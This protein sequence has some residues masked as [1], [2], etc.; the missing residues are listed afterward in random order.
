MMD[1]VHHGP[2]LRS[3]DCELG[4]TV[5]RAHAHSQET[6]PSKS[7]TAPRGSATARHVPGSARPRPA[8]IQPCLGQFETRPVLTVDWSTMTVDLVPHV[9]GTDTLD[10]HVRC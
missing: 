3:M 2:C 4:S 5:S 9:S 7:P 10:P 6:K 8:Q 1:S